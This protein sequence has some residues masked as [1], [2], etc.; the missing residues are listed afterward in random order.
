VLAA[1]CAG[2]A[3]YMT[4]IPLSLTAWFLLLWCYPYDISFTFTFLPSN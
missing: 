1:N 4:S 3:E 2:H